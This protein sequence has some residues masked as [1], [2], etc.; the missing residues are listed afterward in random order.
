MADKAGSHRSTVSARTLGRDVLLGIGAK[1]IGN[2]KRG[3]HACWVLPTK[4][5]QAV[6]RLTQAGFGL[7]HACKIVA[8]R[9][10]VLSALE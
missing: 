4:N 9:A 7:V 2:G 1:N 10:D 5:A 6:I 8:K 3:R